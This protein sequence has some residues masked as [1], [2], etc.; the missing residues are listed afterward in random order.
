[1]KRIGL[2]LFAVLLLLTGCTVTTLSNVDVGSNMK[3][4]SFELINKQ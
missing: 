3:N 2:L 4:L 1:M